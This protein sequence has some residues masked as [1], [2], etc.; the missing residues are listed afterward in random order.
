MYKLLVLDMDGTLLN[1]SKK[2]SDVDIEYLRLAQEAGVMVVLCTGRTIYGIENYLSE[3]NLISDDNYSITCSGAFICNNTKTKVIYS[4]N[5]SAESA[6]LI[7]SYAQELGITLNA[8]SNNKLLVNTSNY[9]SYVDAIANNLDIKLVDFNNISGDTPISK[10]T[11]VNEDERMFKYMKEAFSTL[12]AKIKKINPELLH[13]KYCNQ[14]LFSD[15]SKLPKTLTDKF[16]LLKTTPFT[17]EVVNKNINKGIGVMQLADKLGIKREEVICI[18][19]SGNDKHMIEW[20]GLG[21]AMGNAFNEI[22]E[23]ADF[24]TLTNDEGGTSHVIN[25]FIL[26][27]DYVSIVK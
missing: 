19:D 15:I 11:L 27:N 20:A 24:I 23:I 4:N 5:I 12:H 16:S 6:K 21:V 25:K 13:S 18:G 26:N 1:S 7:N 14:N 22:K 3:L 8:Y 2:I 17:I 10:I 9:F